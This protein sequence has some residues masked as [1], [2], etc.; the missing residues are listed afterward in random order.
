MKIL[1]RKVNGEETLQILYIIYI[2]FEE[3]F[4]T[5]TP[6]LSSQKTALGDTLNVQSKCTPMT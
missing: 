1:T 3:L 4:N 2:N 6:L 5:S